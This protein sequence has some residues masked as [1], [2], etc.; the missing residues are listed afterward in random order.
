ME[1][2]SKHSLENVGLKKIK[3]QRKNNMNPTKKE[4]HFFFKKLEPHLNEKNIS[5]NFCFKTQGKQTFN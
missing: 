3:F 4:C 5:P 2:Y 1:M